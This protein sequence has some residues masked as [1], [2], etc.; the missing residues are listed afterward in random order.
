[1]N[2][3]VC[4]IVAGENQLDVRPGRRT[5]VGGENRAKGRRETLEEPTRGGDILDVHFHGIGR[6]RLHQR[7]VEEQLRLVGYGQDLAVGVPIVICDIWVERQACI[8]RKI[9]TAALISKRGWRGGN[10]PVK[11]EVPCVR[12]AFL[13]VQLGDIAAVSGDWKA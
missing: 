6:C 2:L 1:M 9:N 4:L 11:S 13:H 10:A 5:D 7:S 8:G 12:R 3:K